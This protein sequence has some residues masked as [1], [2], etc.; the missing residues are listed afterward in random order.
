[1]SGLDGNGVPEDRPRRGKWLF[2][3]GFLLGLITGVGVTQWR[4]TVSPT[5][6]AYSS[7]AQLEQ[8]HRGQAGPAVPASLDEVLQIAREALAHLQANVDDYT[9]TLIQQESVAGMMGEP[10]EM[11]LKVQCRHRGGNLQETEPLR[12]YLRFDRPQSVAGREVIWAEDMYD[13]KLVAHEGGLL[14]LM[15][16]RLDP[17]GL[18]AMRGQR[19]PI[20]EIGLTNLVKKLIERGEQDRGN[21]D[22]SFTITQNWDVNGQPCEL[23]EVKRA[24]PSGQSDDFYRAEICF[25]RQRH[26]PLRYAAYGWPQ[27]PGD[28]Q[29]APL[30]ESYTYLDIKTNVGLTAAD[31]D[32]TNPSYQFR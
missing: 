28:P 16:L 21:P 7:G 3:P 29:S 19:Y 2:V 11:H 1:M 27:E 25:D 24:R 31:F 14:G 8:F 20:Y 6:A 18:I 13:G 26:L 30:L 10:H 4:G 22:V 23:I 9:A 12:I 32:L 17:Q 15:T 5:P